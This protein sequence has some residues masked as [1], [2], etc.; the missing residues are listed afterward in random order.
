MAIR[1]LTITLSGFMSLW[2]MGGVLV[3]MYCNP[4]PTSFAMALHLS[5]VSC[6]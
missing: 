5:S 1:L 2:M 6:K 4:A 3:C